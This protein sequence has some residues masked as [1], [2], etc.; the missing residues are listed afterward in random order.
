MNKRILII[1]AVLF[2]LLLIPAVVPV[3]A[4][5][6]GVYVGKD[7][8]ADGTTIIARSC[9]AHPIGINSSVCILERVE[10]TPGRY[11]EGTN[12]FVWPLPDTTWKYTAVHKGV[13]DDEQLWGTGTANEWGLA[14]SATV[15]AY[16]SDAALKADPDVEDGITE[17]DI[18]N[19]LAASCKTAREAVELLCRILDG[20]G[21]SEQNIIMIADQDETWYIETYTGHQYAAVKLPTDKAAVFGNEFMLET[22]SAYDE[23]ITSKEL[24]SLP[25]ENGFAEYSNGELN[26]FD[27]YA[28]KNRLADYSNLRTWRGH[29]LL[30]P[31][32]AGEYKTKTKYPLLFTPDKKVSVEDVITVFR[33]R[34]DGTPYCPEVNGDGKTRVIATETAYSVHVIQIYDTLPKEMAI[35]TWV[36]LSNASYAPFI[37]L[38]NYSTEVSPMYANTANVN[39]YD[40]NTAFSHYKQLNA[41]AAQDHALYGKGVREYWELAERYLTSTYPDFI[42]DTAKIYESDKETAQILINSYNTAVQNLAVS[43]ADRLFEDLMWYI[44]QNTDTLKYKFSYKTL[45]YNDE[46]VEIKPFV[47]DFDAVFFG[48]L[49]E[50]NIS[51]DDDAMTM[52]KDGLT[53]II[54]AEKTSG[55]TPASG[56]E[57]GKRSLGTVT[58]NGRET[59]YTTYLKDGTVYLPLTALQEIEDSKMKPVLTPVL[60]NAAKEV[61]E[62]TETPAPASPLPVGVL[63]AAL[64]AAG[65]ITLYRK[66]R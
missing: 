30:S 38:S 31:S 14:V 58:V 6:T 46:P 17:G 29:Q 28:G 51:Y 36:C 1:S 44:V 20:K 48:E 15:T 62:K 21:T 22:L 23:V 66:E 24:F 7:V 59:E 55:Y 37:P 49:F 42:R 12:G 64:G 2:I 45:T 54:N 27:T 52:E 33:D 34:Y 53:I 8:S 63:T 47:P 3:S 50:W 13:V 32:T 26:L 57:E 43:D 60:T 11:I 19:L 61:A 18:P 41:L 4:D 10:N 16:S 25:K 35:V 65:F 9:D 40:E 56:E 39:G 5:C